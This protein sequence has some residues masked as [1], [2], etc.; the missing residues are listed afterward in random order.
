MGMKRIKREKPDLLK[1]VHDAVRVVRQTTEEMPEIGI[2]LGTGL[3]N[4]A[5]KIKM[6]AELDYE[7]IPNFPVSTVESH[8]GKLIL[9]RLARRIYL[10]Q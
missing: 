7:K 2:I 4:L 8:T 5:Q 9:G 1:S 3:G 6:V 10:P